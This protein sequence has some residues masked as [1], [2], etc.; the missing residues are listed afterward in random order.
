MN[1]PSFYFLPVL[2]ANKSKILKLDEKPDVLTIKLENLAFI[3]T[4]NR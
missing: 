1:Y 2:L 3:G 4:Q